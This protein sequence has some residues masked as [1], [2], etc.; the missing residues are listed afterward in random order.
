MYT[1]V[2][3]IDDGQGSCQ[4]EPGG[5]DHIFRVVPSAS[6]TL[7]AT[8]GND[9]EGEPACPAEFGGEIPPS[10]YDRAIHIRRVC[11]DVSTEVACADNAADSFATEIAT[12]AVTAGE[13]YYVFVDGY[14]AEYYSMGQYVLRLGLTP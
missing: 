1:T 13:E 11:A 12:T 9:F 2:G 10:C 4:G 3:A 8:L 7:T 6:G 5:P 14:N